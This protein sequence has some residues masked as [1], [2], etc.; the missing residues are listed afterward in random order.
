MGT[1]RTSSGVGYRFD[2]GV[3]LTLDR[4][5]FLPWRNYPSGPRA[6]HCRGFMITLRHTTLSRTP[7]DE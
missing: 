6:P 2:T 7:L 1:F 3:R 4:L 5:L